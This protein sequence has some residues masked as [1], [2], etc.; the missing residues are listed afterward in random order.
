MKKLTRAIAAIMLSV[1]FTFVVGCKKDDGVDHQYDDIIKVTTFEPTE[2]T[3][4]SAV[5]GGKAEVGEGYVLSN[6]RFGICWSKERNPKITDNC[7]YIDSLGVPFEKML[8]FELEPNTKYPSKGGVKENPFHMK[9][10][11]FIC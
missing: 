7:V 2:I 9:L 6:F 1:V 4:V 10:D 5:S 8:L 3:H 11:Y